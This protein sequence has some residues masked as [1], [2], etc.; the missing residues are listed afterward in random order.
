MRLDPPKGAAA[1]S[2]L[3][4]WAL[5]A[6]GPA[7]LAPSGAG[8]LLAPSASAQASTIL[9][10]E[11]QS[12]LNDEGVQAIIDGDPD[13]AIRIFRASLDLGHL[14]VTWLNLGRALAKAG[15]CDEAVAAYDAV[16]AAPQVP[17]PPPEVVAGVLERYRSE[18]IG[19]CPGVLSVACSPDGVQ[20]QI[21]D[22]P[23]IDCPAEGLTLSPGEHR[24]VGV[25][26]EERVEEVVTIVSMERAQLTLT[27]K[28]P[29]VAIGPEIIEPPQQ[30]ALGTW[31]WIAAGTGGAALLAALAVDAV[32]ISPDIKSLKEL[33]TQPGQQESFDDLK[34]SIEGAQGLNLGLLISGGALV[35]TGVLLIAFAPDVEPSAEGAKAAPSLSIW[36][37]PSS[38]GLGM[39]GTW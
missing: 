38:T 21:D 39:T 11:A 19:P 2:T 35:V 16:E 3:I 31:G 6:L 28:T 23:P 17:D 20:L 26:A 12:Q 25:L 33:R 5:V 22:Q 18:L 8:E 29:V 37:G 30:G 14:N 36:A 34:S 27:L 13:K 4:V 10:T 9:A 15:R 1:L 7:L 24:V 32:S